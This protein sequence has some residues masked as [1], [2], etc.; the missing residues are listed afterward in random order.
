MSARLPWQEFIQQLWRRLTWFMQR[1]DAASVSY[2]SIVGAFAASIDTHHV[3]NLTKKEP[4]PVPLTSGT[5]HQFFA[6]SMPRVR[7]H[8]WESGRQRQ[9]QGMHYGPRRAAAV[10]GEAQR[11]LRTMQSSPVNTNLQKVLNAWNRPETLGASTLMVTASFALSD[12]LVPEEVRQWMCDGRSKVALRRL[13]HF[14]T[15]YW[16]HKAKNTKQSFMANT[17]DKTNT[18]RYLPLLV[19]TG[20]VFTRPLACRAIKLCGGSGFIGAHPAG[21]IWK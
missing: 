11:K 19:R 18:C 6:S 9:P 8:C 12:F 16:K 3:A 7:K 4:G 10:L 13:Q 21:I 1:C 2:R 17:P 14:N 20:T 15:M 5:P